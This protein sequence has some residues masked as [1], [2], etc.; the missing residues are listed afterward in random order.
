MKYLIILTT[1]TVFLIGLQTASAEDSP[2]IDVLFIGNSYTTVNNL[3]GMLEALSAKAKV[4]RQVKTA[5][6]T[7]GGWTLQKH[8]DD[9]KQGSQAAIKKGKWDYVVLQEQS[10]MP[11]M[12]PKVTHKFG[13]LFGKLIQ[14]YKATPL[15]YITWA[16]QHQPENQVKIKA[17]YEGMA[18]A[19]NAKIA[20]VGL[21]WERVLK[22]NPGIKLHQRDK[23]HPSPEG[24]YLTACV[25]FSV[26]YDQSPVGLP[27]TLTAPKNGGVRVLCKL[28]PD[29]AKTLQLA[30]W[31][32]VKQTPVAPK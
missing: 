1:L 3:P 14:E 29:V 15:F 24:T 30:A 27:A 20:P 8:W 22:A 17:T 10:Q 31:E 11:F 7:H 19:L 13:L 2:T 26:I 4:K 18:K 23:S 21:A 28:G 6:S 32:T 12:Y 25:F 16:R 5:R 9:E